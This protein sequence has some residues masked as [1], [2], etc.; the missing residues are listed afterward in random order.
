MQRERIITGA[1][2]AQALVFGWLHEPAATRKQL[3]VN[4]IESGMQMS[5]Q[6]FDQRF[7]AA[8]VA[9]MRALLEAALEQVVK[10]AERRV[11]LPQ[12]KG[13]VV[14]D[15]TALKWGAFRLKV[16]TRLDLQSG[17]LQLSLE[18]PTVHD[19][20]TQVVAQPGAASGRPGIFQ[21]S[22]LSGVECRRRVLVEPF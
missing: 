19:Q 8:G 3:H 14:T 6:G 13:V 20:K 11:V 22:P 15:C 2:F 1:G 21:V 5:L 16:A 7:N 10:S 9:F 12:F 17:H 4:S 18:A